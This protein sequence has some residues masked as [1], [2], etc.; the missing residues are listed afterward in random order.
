[1]QR[2]PI[3]QFEKVLLLNGISQIDLNNLRDE[4]DHEVSDA[5]DIAKSWPEPSRAALFEDVMV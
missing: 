1:M 3:A 5:V 4:V 2:D